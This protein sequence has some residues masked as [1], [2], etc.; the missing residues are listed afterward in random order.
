MMK[1][2]DGVK[3]GQRRRQRFRLRTISSLRCRRRTKATL[4]PQ[5]TSSKSSRL[6]HIVDV[7]DRIDDSDNASG[8]ASDSDS[9][10]EGREAR[11]ARGGDE[12]AYDVRHAYIS[13]SDDARFAAVISNRPE[14]SV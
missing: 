14:F 8:D 12:D 7:N 10:D 5:V 9:N 3:R 1:M 2:A 4:S 6:L 11:I 13:P